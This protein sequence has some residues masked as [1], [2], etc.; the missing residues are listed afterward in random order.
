MNQGI[1]Q[2]IDQGIEAHEP[3]VASGREYF[4]FNHLHQI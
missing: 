3:E 2:G 1:D 4:Q